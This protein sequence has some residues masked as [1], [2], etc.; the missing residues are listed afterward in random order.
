MPCHHLQGTCRWS[1]R[2]SW[3]EAGVRHEATG[4]EVFTDAQCLGPD[5]AG[6][7]VGEA[8]VVASGEAAP[9]SLC[10]PVLNTVPSTIGEVEG[11]EAGGELED[12]GVED[13]CVGGHGDAGRSLDVF[14]PAEEGDDFGWGAE[15]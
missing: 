15:G 11:V 12:V 14:G 3:L 2:S 7:G 13:L 1:K 9:G 8:V 10:L 5:E 6:A 4:V